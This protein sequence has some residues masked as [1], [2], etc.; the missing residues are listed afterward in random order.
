MRVG[1]GFLTGIVIAWIVTTGITTVVMPNFLMIANLFALIV[2][3][4][5]DV[6]KGFRQNYKY[7]LQFLLG[8]LIVFVGIVLYALYVFKFLLG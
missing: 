5:I 3:I 2:V 4:I 7:T 1:K 8:Q 6:K